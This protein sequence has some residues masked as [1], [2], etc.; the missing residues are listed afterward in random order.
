MEAII[1]TTDLFDGLVLY[2]ESEFV[3]ADEVAVHAI[4]RSVAVHVE[5]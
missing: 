5:H 2:A 4:T 3:V 1:L